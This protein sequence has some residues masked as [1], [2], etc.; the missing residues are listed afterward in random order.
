MTNS[1]NLEEL[2][3]SSSQT[4]P[5]LKKL[6]EIQA[7]ADKATKGPWVTF[8][9]EGEAYNS[10]PATGAFLINYGAD[11]D[12]QQRDV[13]FMARSREE[14]PLLV[15]ALKAALAT[16]ALWDQRYPGIARDFE[17]TIREALG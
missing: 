10:P 14:V 1:S 13:N 17:D 11:H 2:D 12:Q 7:S 8:D 9:E 4:P 5:T 6:D 3:N 16:A 15:G